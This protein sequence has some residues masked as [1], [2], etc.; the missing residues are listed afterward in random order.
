MKV[1]SSFLLVAQLAALPASAA[2]RPI[3]GKWSGG[4]ASC[5]LPFAISGRTY[6]APGATPKRVVKVERSGGW[7]RIELADRYAFVLMNVKPATMT[8][9]SPASG[10]TFDLTRCH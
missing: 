9:H 3:D 10:D 7:W 4:P 2:G 5:S 8:W 6:V 1:L